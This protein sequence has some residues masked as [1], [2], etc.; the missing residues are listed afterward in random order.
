MKPGSHAWAGLNLISL[1]HALLCVDCDFISENL[2]GACARCGGRGVLQLA[3]VLGGPMHPTAREAEASAEFSP[4]F[5]R[6][7]QEVLDRLERQF[8]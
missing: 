8:I 4:E 3:Q 7:V 5:E 1:R 2:D 6:Q